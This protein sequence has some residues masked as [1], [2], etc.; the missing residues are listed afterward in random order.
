[1]YT[2]IFLLD[3]TLK[4]AAAQE[5]AILDHATPLIYEITLWKV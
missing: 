4:A 5:Y 1:M 2:K 3:A